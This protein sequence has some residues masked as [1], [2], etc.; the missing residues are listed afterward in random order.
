MSVN[1]MKIDPCPFCG[2]DKVV[3]EFAGSQGYIECKNCYAT[4]PDDPMAADPH[5]DIDAAVL[6][7]NRRILRTCKGNVADMTEAVFSITIKNPVFAAEL[8]YANALLA[9]Y[10]YSKENPGQTSDILQKRI[11][12]TRK[13]AQALRKTERRGG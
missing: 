10:N 12:V 8:N 6:I 9:S 4:G 1:D 2:S 5:C 3:Y 7:W 11:I 13:L